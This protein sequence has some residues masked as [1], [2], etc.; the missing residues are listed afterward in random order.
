MKENQKIKAP[1]R[2]SRYYACAGIILLGIAVRLI[3]LD[4]VPAHNATAD[5]YAWTWSGMTLLTEGAPRSWSWLKPYRNAKVTQWKGNPYRL[6]QPWFDHPPVYSLLMGA[7]MLPEGRDIFKVSLFRMRLMSL[8]LFTIS[9]ILLASILLRLLSL[10]VAL[11]ALAAFAVAPP[12]VFHTKL[13]ISENLLLPVF[14]V[15]IRCILV[16]GDKPKRRH[17][18]LLG[19][20]VLVIP[21]IKIAGLAMS[22]GLFIVS[23]L[24]RRATHAILIA[25]ATGLGLVLLF[26]YAW[27]LNL[28][29]FIAVM[30]AHAARFSGFNVWHELLF[31]HR[32]LSEEF[33][34]W[35]F[36]VGLIF[37]TRELSRG[38]YRDLALLCVTYC[39][40]LNFFAS[41]SEVYGWYLMPVHPFLCI[42]VALF[43]G[44]FWYKPGAPYLWFW[45]PLTLASSCDLLMQSGA[46][47]MALRYG[48][49]LLSIGIPTASSLIKL[50]LT[51]YR[52]IAVLMLAVQVITDL[53]RDLA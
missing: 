50:S 36:L 51:S 20:G 5:E 18:V 16:F 15:C 22:L 26:I 30:R 34:Y 25:A 10:R 31:K 32:I 21:L 2:L 33:A 42:G 48:F 35:P 11:V 44:E 3:H 47:A 13:V 4:T 23:L 40:G 28:D 37:L 52:G 24:H 8:L 49:L 46:N 14:L 43:V 39:I 38:R 29:L 53:F 7:W 27:W 12:V 41:Q 45:V 6:V 19:L 1:P 9:S 17:L